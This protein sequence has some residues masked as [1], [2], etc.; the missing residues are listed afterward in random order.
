M[1]P[2]GLRQKDASDMAELDFGGYTPA[3]PVPFSGDGTLLQI[4]F[5]PRYPLVP[6]LFRA[7]GVFLILAAS[8][9]W[10]LPGSRSET[11]LIL[12]KL[13]ASLF[14]LLCGLALVML[15]QPENAPEVCF[16]PIRRELRVVA[17]SADGAPHVVLRRGYESLGQVRFYKSR[18]EL[19]DFDGRLLLNLRIGDPERRAAL[20]A[21]LRQLV[22]I[23]TQSRPTCS[24]DHRPCWF[25]RPCSQPQH[26]HIA[27]HVTPLNQTEKMG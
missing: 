17:N 25:L 8:A 20:E 1:H 5:G 18:V 22:P 7:V 24:P 15:H 26:W 9:M 3:G 4:A 12:L 27:S 10:F 6:V 16:D 2:G 11:E 23:S 13:G 14:F 21:Q 19:Y